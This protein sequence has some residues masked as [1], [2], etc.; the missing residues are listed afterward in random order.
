MKKIFIA[1]VIFCFTI[2]S[3]FTNTTTPIKN[4]MKS[5]TVLSDSAVIKRDVSLNLSKGDNTAEIVGLPI[6][7]NDNSLKVKIL[8]NDGV[9]IKDIKIQRTF[10]SQQKNPKIEQLIKQLDELNL[11]ITNLINEK[12][13]LTNSIE[14]IKKVNINNKL[15][16]QELDDFVNFSE[17]FISKKLDRIS[18]IDKEIEK[19]EKDKTTIQNE[20][21]LMRNQTKETKN[22]QLILYSD[23]N[24]TIFMEITYL[25]SGVRWNSSYEINGDSNT[26]KISI[27]QFVNIKQSTGE[28]WNNVELEISTAKPSAGTIPEITPIYLEKAKPLIVFTKERDD[29][30]AEEKVMKKANKSISFFEP[31]V[32]EETT[33]FTF[34]LPFK[35]SIPSDNN[36]Y[37]FQLA[38]RQEKGE[39][40]Y[41]A[42]PKLSS[43]VF[44]TATTKNNFGYPL[45]AGN[46]NVYLDGMFISTFN[47]P[48]TLPDE[49]INLSFGQDESIKVDRKQVRRFT[50][51][52]GIGDKNVRIHYEYLITLKN[53]KKRSVL[54]NIKDQ[55]PVSKDEMIK[56]IQVEPTKDKATISDDGI[57]SWN[58]SIEPS[59]KKE[60]KLRYK[61]EYPK[62]YKVSGLE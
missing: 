12:N 20:I 18:I 44:L 17:K 55:F 35:V 48:K 45:L 7:M 34:T 27:G 3:G 4:T 31:E 32:K 40:F 61:V 53:G 26:E 54:L 8:N 2:T 6:S 10:L 38:E 42:V 21:N 14:Y 25:I 43:S 39:F 52:F 37:K 58:I 46:A 1:M 24:T 36:F 9:K 19:L 49:E 16:T 51:Y 11:K 56:V 22:L 62:N 13:V 50:E 5:V 59:E 15:T 28:D 41:Y 60:L 30:F 57:V 29:L 47:L 33:S 23:K